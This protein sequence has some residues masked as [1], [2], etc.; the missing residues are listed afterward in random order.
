MDTDSSVLR[1]EY[2]CCG[3][4]A[5]LPFA[6][7]LAALPTAP[8]CASPSH[9]HPCVPSSTCNP[10]LPV[11]TPDLPLHRS[12]LSSAAH[13]GR[14]N[15]AQP[16]LLAY[17]AFLSLFCLDFIFFS[18]SA[19]ASWNSHLNNFNTQL[20]PPLLPQL[21]APEASCLCGHAA[22]ELT[23]KGPVRVF[24]LFSES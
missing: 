13:A 17:D 1:C 10:S 15:R 5:S 16:R 11:P 4:A 2:P 23:I 7:S 20:L 21:T 18:V 8:P 12:S 9:P 22:T 6:P 3:S 14:N 24:K 19:C